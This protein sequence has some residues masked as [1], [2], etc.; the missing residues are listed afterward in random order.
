[1]NLEKEKLL[2]ILSNINKIFPIV[3]KRNIEDNT[4]EIIAIFLNLWGSF[5]SGGRKYK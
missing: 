2:K 3:I 1:M 5:K 4:I